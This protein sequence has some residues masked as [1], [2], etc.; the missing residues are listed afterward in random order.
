M[1]IISEDIDNY[2]R[3]VASGDWGLIPHSFSQQTFLYTVHKL[4]K[5]RV[6]QPQPPLV[7]KH[8]KNCVPVQPGNQRLMGLATDIC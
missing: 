6:A 4:D 1:G 7:R 8:D 2:N 5:V 3:H